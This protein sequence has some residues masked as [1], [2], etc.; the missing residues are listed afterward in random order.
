M[1]STAIRQK[2]E[3]EIIASFVQSALAKG[4]RLAVSRERGYDTESMLLGCRNRKRI[5]DYVMDSDDAH[6][7]VQ[8]ATGSLLQD[9]RVVSKG[10]VYIVLGNEGWDVISDYTT[11]LEP[12]MTGANRLAEKY[13]N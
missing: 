6:I 11:N 7:F 9:G 4:Y 2:I 3:R 5:T 10:W 1:I 12:L 8:P 13:G